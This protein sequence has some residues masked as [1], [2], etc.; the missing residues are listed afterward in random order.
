[1]SEQRTSH[2]WK[3]LRRSLALFVVACSLGGAATAVAKPPAKNTSVDQADERKKLGYILLGTSCALSLGMVGAYLF[4][5]RRRRTRDIFA[6]E[7]FAAVG[8]VDFSDQRSV[9]AAGRRSKAAAE[10]K[11]GSSDAAIEALGVSQTDFNPQQQLAAPQRECPRCSRM[12]PSTILV[13]PYDSTTLRPAHKPQRQ[14]KLGKADGLERLVCTGCGRRYKPGVDYCY[15]DGLPLMQ[16]T[17]ERADHAPAFQACESCGWEGEADDERL[18]PNDGSDLVEIDPSDS[19]HVRPAIPMT[20]CPTCG[21]YGMPGQAFCPND[22]DVLTPVLNMRVTEFPA[23]GFGPR[24]KV[25][26]ECGAEHGRH[27]SYCS[28]DGSKLVALN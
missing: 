19:T 4:V 23:R 21:Q 14:R 2:L 7:G 26:G 22:G 8:E 20:V 17:R 18:C 3:C 13:C 25:C 15:H 27:A 12:Y 16:D 1:M 24:R 28:N 5:R 6:F 11:G 9:R 10:Q